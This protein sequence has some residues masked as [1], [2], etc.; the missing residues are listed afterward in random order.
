MPLI[1]NGEIVSH[2]WSVLADADDPILD[3]DVVIPISRVREDGAD[4]A[5]RS[6]R[7]GLILNGDAELD[8]L[9]GQLHRYPLIAV[10]F[11]AFTDGRGFSLARALRRDFGYAGELWATGALIP[12]QQ[13]FLRACGF[14]AVLLDE[15]IFARQGTFAWLSTDGEISLC[16]QPNH[17]DGAGA[18]RSIQ[19]LRQASRRLQAAE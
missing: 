10:A 1:R 15:Q 8:S 14:D 5:G 11:P 3:G 7:I 4:L 19:T 13:S 17:D 9:R 6:G 16:Y 18:P 12:D 2:S